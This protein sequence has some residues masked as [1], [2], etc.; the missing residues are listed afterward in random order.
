[1]DDKNKI[2]EKA[3]KEFFAIIDNCTI[4]EYKSFIYFNEKFKYYANILMQIENECLK[5]SISSKFPENSKELYGASIIANI[6][7]TSEPVYPPFEKEKN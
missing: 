4:S 6:I 7:E 5:K 2:I 3:G 1:M